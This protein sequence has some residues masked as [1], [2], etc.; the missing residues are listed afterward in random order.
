MR[1][2]SFCKRFVCGLV[3]FC[4]V[5][6]TLLFVGFFMLS[7]SQVN[8]QMAPFIM[9]TILIS[10]LTTLF[11]LINNPI[12]YGNPIPFYILLIICFFTETLY[13]SIQDFLYNGTLGFKCV[14][15]EVRYCDN[16]NRILKIIIRNILKTISR[17]LYGIPLFTMFFSK[18]KQTFYDIIT[19]SI[20][21]EK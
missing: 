4:I 13:Y 6:I 19:T 18:K 8:Q 10:P 15:I 7:V 11:D 12:A 5:F 14:G 16:K 17:Y 9:I 21:V 3:D 2:P 1:Y 20:V